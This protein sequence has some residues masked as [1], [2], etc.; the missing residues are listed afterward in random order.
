L[1]PNLTRNIFKVLFS[2]L[3]GVC[4]GIVTGFVV[5]KWLGVTGYAEYKTYLLYASFI[6][7]LS[8]G[9]VDGIYLKY[10]GKTTD[11]INAMEIS[12]EL[13]FFIVTQTFFAL[14]LLLFAFFYDFRILIPMAF[15]VI[16]QSLWGFYLL[17]FQAS[18][19]FSRYASWNSLRPVFNLFSILT[20]ILI[21]N[22]RNP[23]FLIWA[24]VI[25]TWILMTGLLFT[26]P[27]RIHFSF[28]TK[29]IFKKAHW[30]HI[31]IGIFIM[32]G[33]FSGILFY[34]MDRWFV[35]ILLPK[36]EFA[37]YSFAT[38]MMSLVLILI[39]SV[40]I[41]FYP[42][43]SQNTTNL[44]LISH[45]KDKLIVLG[46]FAAACYFAFAYITISF[47]P[48][49]VESLKV[50][51]YLFA[52]LPAIAVIQPIYVNLYKVAKL[53]RRY[54]HQVGL[55]ALISF[56]FNALAVLVHKSNETIAL[57][58]T[59]TFY[60]WFFCYPRFQKEARPSSRSILFLALFCV[61]FILSSRCFTHITG[62][63][64]FITC[65]IIITQIIFPDVNRWLLDKSKQVFSRFAC[66]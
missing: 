12:Y 9:F 18:D 16:P 31:F 22:S 28:S 7:L 49:Y 21:F 20:I 56:L 14:V 61:N 8:L 45:M 4:L 55:M 33:N 17:L 32:L 51:S 27:F 30:N 13:Q 24:Q 15:V 39:N 50:I 44:A 37:F 54:F 57:A 66:N 1:K 19:Q 35:K 6:P 3:V 52:G 43:L 42:F 48:E 41:T 47:L 36:P 5:P 58:T 11:E 53:E 26:C 46:S 60:V 40:S 23:W 65:Q 29:Q 10:G 25:V 62:G 2:H 59:M 38:S 63:L 34:S 64:I